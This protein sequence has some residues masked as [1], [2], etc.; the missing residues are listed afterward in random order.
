MDEDAEVVDSLSVG[1]R[2]RAAREEKGFS[3]EDLAAETRIPRRHLE[4]LEDSDWDRLPA[5]TY[6]IGFAKSY[7][8]A[9]GLDRAEIAEQI[10]GEMGGTRTRSSTMETFEPVDPAR[11][12]P[13][14]L[15]LAAIAAVILIVIFFTWM[16]NRE[17]A[18]PEDSQIGAAEPPP[19]SSEPTPRAQ[20][21]AARPAAEGPVV[22]T[23]LAPA[24]IR[25]TDQGS[26]LFEGMMQP[27]QSYTVPPSASAPL[28]RAGAPEALRVTVGDTVA[29]PVGPA[30]QVTSNVSLKPADLLRPQA[31]SGGGA[32]PAQNSLA[33]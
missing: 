13:K 12:M 22:L 18:G 33:Q 24:W 27:G 32:S 8:S 3:L 7:A 16:Q 25:V 20:A 9:V 29:P 31:A 28:L 19:P 14:W 23:A 26:I 17:L 5:P 11:T 15:V 10:R 30:G 1:D 6:T 4:S 21:P 2:L